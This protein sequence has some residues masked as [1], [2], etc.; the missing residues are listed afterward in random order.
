[1]G[2]NNSQYHC[3]MLLT[4]RDEKCPLW[5]VGNVADATLTFWRCLWLAGTAVRITT[6]SS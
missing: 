5:K 2:D 3:A 4:F 1:M 6:V